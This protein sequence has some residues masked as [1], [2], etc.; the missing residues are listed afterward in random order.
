[1][2][3]TFGIYLATMSV[4]YGYHIRQPSRAGR[5]IM[6]TSIDR[7]AVLGAAP[8]LGLPALGLRPAMAEEAQEIKVPTTRVTGGD[9][10]VS[11][12][13][14]ELTLRPCLVVGRTA[15]ALLGCEQGL[16]DIASVE[17]EPV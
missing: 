17:L 10:L 9:V 11:L 1:M 7:R 15:R 8:L 5:G 12:R 16:A 6:M 14:V 4:C 13:V 2:R 3:A